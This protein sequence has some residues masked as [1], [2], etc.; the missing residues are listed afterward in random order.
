MSSDVAAILFQAHAN[1]WTWSMDFDVFLKKTS[2]IPPSLP[3]VLGV[4]NQRKF[5]LNWLEKRRY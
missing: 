2:L 3:R 4:S 5:R 1:Y